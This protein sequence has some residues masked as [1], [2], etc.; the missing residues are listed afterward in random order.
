MYF[1]AASAIRMTKTASSTFDFSRYWDNRTSVV[2]LDDKAFDE[3]MVAGG[4]NDY[5]GSYDDRIDIIADVGGTV[6][7]LSLYGWN[8]RLDVD[9]VPVGG[10]I[11]GLTAQTRVGDGWVEDF[12]FYRDFDG[13][14]PTIAVL[15]FIAAAQT[16]GAGD[17]IPLVRHLLS[18]KPG[19]EVMAVTFPMAT[20]GCLG[21]RRR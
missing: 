20:T 7:A 17:D 1:S 11:G 15:D 21:G 2:L 13:L 6:L 18:E 5:A 4:P 10:R 19:W 14:D 3:D 8:L 16:A 12:R 9:A